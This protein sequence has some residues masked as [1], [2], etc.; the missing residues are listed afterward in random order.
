MIQRTTQKMTQRPNLKTQADIGLPAG[1]VEAAT[2]AIMEVATEVKIATRKAATESKE[3]SMMDL[4]NLMEQKTTTE[5]GIVVDCEVMTEQRSM[6][7]LGNM[8]GPGSIKEMKIME[9]N[10]VE[11]NTTASWRRMVVM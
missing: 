1:P 2:E 11:R 5:Q 7:D 9:R 4:E 3:T 8:M 10:T 6:A